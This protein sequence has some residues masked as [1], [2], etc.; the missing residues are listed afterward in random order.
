MLVS[1]LNFASKTP[2]HCL[3][4]NLLLEWLSGISGTSSYQEELSKVVRV[5]IAGIFIIKNIF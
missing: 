4:L 2:D 5:I 1:G 3:S